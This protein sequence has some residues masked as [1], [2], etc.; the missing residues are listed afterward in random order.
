MKVSII[1]ATYNSAHGI[2]AC[3]DSILSQDY[4]NIECLVIDGKSIDQ[5]IEIVSEKQ[6][7]HSSIN[8][9][10]EP[11]KGIYDALNKGVNLASGDIIGFVH[12]DDLLA[13]KTVISKLVS[14]FLNEKIDG[15]Y[16]DLQ[17]VNKDDTSRVVRLW[18]S[19][20]FTTDLL[21]KGW[22][23]AHPTFFLKKEVY[24]IHGKFNLKYKIAAD[25]DFMVRVLKDPSLT[26]GYMPCV[27]TKM[28]VGGISNGGL[29][30]IIL[31]SKEDYEV[32]HSN[33]I[34]GVLTLFKKNISKLSQFIIR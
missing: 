16:G 23:P 31:K 12:S 7:K 26:Y 8:I 14:K 34:G 24:K 6:K 18:K 5:T 3:L 1:T 25:Y 32:L 13:S 19:R 28:R 21:S 27:I 30:N 10:S 4:K 9:V 11:D 29:K 20:D 2:E 17:Y 22:M 33:K 15:V